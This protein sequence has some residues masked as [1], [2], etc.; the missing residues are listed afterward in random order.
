MPIK[1]HSAETFVCVSHML[2]SL[3]LHGYC[4]LVNL[5][6]DRLNFRIPGHFGPHHLHVSGGFED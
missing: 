2:A 5:R 4:M 6:Y 1:I 3:Q